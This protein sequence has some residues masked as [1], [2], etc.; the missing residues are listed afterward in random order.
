MLKRNH[1]RVDC[2][3]LFRCLQVS[4]LNCKNRDFKECNFFQ[5]DL[6]RYC[7]RIRGN[8]EACRYYEFCRD[9]VRKQK[10][11]EKKHR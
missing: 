5:N 11:K 9:P 8:C 1:T 3:L 2:P 7:G 4:A 10:L 6:S